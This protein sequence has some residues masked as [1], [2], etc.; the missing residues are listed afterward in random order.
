MS[1]DGW[2]LSTGYSVIKECHVSGEEE[3]LLRDT[4]LSVNSAFYAGYR[5]IFIAIGL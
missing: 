4:E 3:A 2:H 1:G 5:T